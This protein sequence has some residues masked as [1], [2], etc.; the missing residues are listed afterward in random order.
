[1]TRDDLLYR[2][3]RHWLSGVLFL[4]PLIFYLV[5]VLILHLPE[6]YQ[7]I[8][9]TL[10]AVMG[11]HVLD[12]LFLIKDT[13]EALD[14]LSQDIRRDISIQTESLTDTSKSL[15][16]MARSGIIQIYPSRIEAAKDIRNDIAD[17][18]NSKVRLI[19]I[20]LNDFVQGMDQTLME[21]WNTIQAFVRNEKSIDDRKRG[22]DIRVLIIDPK[23]FGAKLRSEAES[24]SSSALQERLETDVHAAAKDL[25]KL[26]TEA[27]P[28]ETGVGF[29]CRLY[30]LPPTL[31]L[32][33]VD[34]VCYVQQYHFWSS[35]DNRT[36]TPILKFRKLAASAT[37]YPYHREMEHHFDWI[38][39]NAAISVDDYLNAAVVG[40]D[41]GINQCGAENFYTDSEKARKRIVYLLQ[42][43]EKKVSIQGI[44]LNSFFKPGALREAVSGVLETGKA[45]LEILLLDPDSEQAKYRSYRERLF[46][47]ED[48]DYKSYLNQGEHEKSELYQ[49]TNRTIQ[50]IRHM[51]EDIGRRKDDS[52]WM[53]RLKVGLYGSAPACFILRVD[54]RV[55]V[56]QY[57]YGKIVRETRAILGKD[58][59]LVEYSEA[60]S[61][62]YKDESN[63]LRR[64]FGLL[65]D[66]FNYALAQARKLKLMEA[67]NDTPRRTS[68]T[69]KKYK[70]DQVAGG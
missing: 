39:E 1:M 30:R 32:C 20:S 49:D 22:L 9:L 63:P 64:P 18:A 17:P 65:V 5:G 67:T 70:R 19:G 58:M 55:L 2:F 27:N 23:C 43:A 15:E 53:P 51:I 60:P 12:R 42:H 31:F 10:T 57:H 62:L 3:K 44:S 69:E 11:I 38:W 50:N 40:I 41:Q 54:D 29:Q 7:H 14:R 16:A 34:S 46:V 37:T 26:T 24:K 21:A 47:S 8:M 35:R 56:E 48:Q 6:L 66:H 59:P 68:Y 33:W 52:K 28:D 13:E 36:P 25:Q 61:Q 4:I 45:E